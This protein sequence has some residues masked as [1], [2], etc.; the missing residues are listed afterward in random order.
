MAGSI[1]K[2]DI[3]EIKSRIRIDDLVSAYVTLKPAGMDSLKGLCPFHDEKTP[4]FHVR[5]S[6]GTWHCFGCSEGGDS[7]SFVQNIEHINFAEAVEF[8][9]QK[10]GYTIH[11]T[12]GEK[13]TTPKGPSKQR[14]VD[15]HRV[16]IEFYQ[17]QLSTNEGTQARLMLEKR[18]FDADTIKKYEIGYSPQSWDSLTTHLR[19]HGFSDQEIIASGLS[20][21]GN[22]GLYDRFRGR[23]MWP[24][25]SITSDPIGFGARKLN[26]DEDGP[27]YL[28][29]PETLIYKKSHVLYG[30]NIAKKNIATKK[31]IVVV[32]GYTDVIAAHL[33]GIDYA[34][35]TCGT[36]F[37]KEHIKIVRRLLGDTYS[38]TTG[39]MMANGN[40]WGG[41]IIFTF[42]GDKAGQKAA[43]KAFSEDQSFAA[44]TFIAVASNN[45]DPCEVRLNYGDE[46][47]RDL[48]ESKR[49]LFEFAIKTTLKNLPLHTAEGRTRGLH[50]SAP[51]VA[52]IRDSILQ[53]E[54]IRLLAGWLGMDEK[55]VEQAV[56]NAKKNNDFPTQMPSDSSQHT[57]APKTRLERL[58][59]EALQIYI[60]LPWCIRDF[61]L[62]NL[63]P[64]TFTSPQYKRIH[65]TINS[66]QALA[67][68]AQKESNYLTQG[69]EKTEAQKKATADYIQ[70]ICEE[71]D[72]KTAQE[73]R[74][75]IASPLP[76]NRH[77]HLAHYAWTIL[78]SLIQEGIQRQIEDQ[79][80]QLQQTNLSNED[81]MDIFKRIQN[82][83][84][85]KRQW[86][87]HTT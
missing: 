9:A 56:K 38:P 23:V 17:Q 15:A 86:N 62:E 84:Q 11:Y 18:G 57:H 35:A 20:S 46:G 87:A 5:P 14:L 6:H 21:Q 59:H 68:F 60:E 31:R 74:A 78:A 29:T 25:F 4:S 80:Y 54:Y 32:E 24:I 50:A 52:H 8:L 51:V 61:H 28:N 41:E 72:E 58:E 30:L 65:Q 71:S 49:P 47:V 16:A 70:Y 34:V 19:K 48:I 43:L 77:N 39:L 36:A 64:H 3:N 2:E 40:A 83:E 66:T 69:I 53:G 27:K 13:R 42:D 81:K 1:P 37:G 22:R 82:L 63:P 75:L 67:F 76:E 33:A 79:R 45:M 26:D 85:Q 12:T 44:Q 7:I 73:I 10:I 55:T